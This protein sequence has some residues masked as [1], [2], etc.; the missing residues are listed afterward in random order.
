MIIV[1]AN[2]TCPQTQ[3]AEHLAAMEIIKLSSIIT[4]QTKIDLVRKVQAE[5]NYQEIR[6]FIQ[7]SIRP[8]FIVSINLYDFRHT[9]KRCSRYTH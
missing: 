3:T 6:K 4:L 1:A 8:H 9:G 7:G 2:E 5:D